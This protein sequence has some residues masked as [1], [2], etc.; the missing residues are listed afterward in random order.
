[1]SRAPVNSASAS[2]GVNGD[3]ESTVRLLDKSRVITNAEARLPH[4]P[5]I[6]RIP[7]SREL[8]LAKPRIPAIRIRMIAT[9]V[10]NSPTGT[11]KKRKTQPTAAHFLFNYSHIPLYLTS[12]RQVG[13]LLNPKELR[14]IDVNKV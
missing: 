2:S 4:A 11:V 14:A 5:A 3:S 6:A 9:N 1:M 7:N 13:I 10:S 12:S 8:P